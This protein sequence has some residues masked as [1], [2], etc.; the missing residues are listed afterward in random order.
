MSFAHRKPF[1]FFDYGD[2]F[3][4]QLRKL[5]KFQVDKKGARRHREYPAVC[6]EKNARWMDRNFCAGAA[7]R[8]CSV[9]Y[10]MK[11]GPHTPAAL[12]YPNEA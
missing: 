3:A 10:P 12:K 4:D 9:Q 5:P 1:A 6:A 7:A 11:G 2:R 8:C